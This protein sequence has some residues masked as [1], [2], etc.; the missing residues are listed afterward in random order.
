MNKYNHH[1]LIKKFVFGYHRSQVLPSNIEKIF[2]D[3]SDFTD[4]NIFFPRKSPPHFEEIENS[5]YQEGE[6]EPIPVYDIAKDMAFSSEDEFYFCH[7][8]YNID[9]IDGVIVLNRS[10]RNNYSYRESMDNC[11]S[12][13]DG[14]LH[15]AREFYAFINDFF[16]GDNRRQYLNGEGSERSNRSDCVAFLHAMGSRN[17]DVSVS[18]KVFKSHLELCFSEYLFLEEESEALY[19]LGIAMHG[20]MDSFTPSHMGFQHYTEQNKAMHAQ[21]DVIPI[22][23]NP[24]KLDKEKRVFGQIYETLYYDYGEEEIYFSPGQYHEEE[25]IIGKMAA[26]NKGYNGEIDTIGEYIM[27]RVFLYIG[28]IRNTKTGELIADKEKV[29][30]K[31]KSFEGISD[32]QNKINEWLLD[33]EYSE[34]AYCYGESALKVMT[35]VYDFL[36][37]KRNECK[38]N[39][40]KYKDVK[41]TIKMAVDL[42]EIEYNK[43]RNIRD[44]HLALHLYDNEMVEDILSEYNKRG[45]PYPLGLYSAP[46]RL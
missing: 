26:H 10:N 21:G 31:W 12:F 43:I 7:F 44:E 24:I 30:K 40:Q 41:K 33:F 23:C 17:E 4:V 34:E 29:E 3:A 5:K 28:K 37:C 9:C 22:R 14:K 45:Y 39:Y 36:S 6:M 42:W 32:L 27:F 20:I 19:M 18:L 11:D 13:R 38:N 15:T 1:R 46:N 8:Y 16:P 2:M 35:D 25:S